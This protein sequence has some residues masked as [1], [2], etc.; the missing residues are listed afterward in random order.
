MK[1]IL[2]LIIISFIFSFTFLETTLAASIERIKGSDRYQTA[3]EISKSGWQSAATV[4]LAKGSDF[5]DA[6]AG[7]P[8]A[9]SLDAPILLTNEMTLTESTKQEILRLKASNIV[10]LGSEGAIS[11]QVETSLRNMG[12]TIDRIGGKHRFETAANI[13]KRISSS[14]AIIANGRNFPDALAVAPYAAKNGIPILLT[15]KEVLPDAT[16]QIAK[17]KSQT[18]IVGKEG[19][20][21]KGVEDRLT[22]TVR[23]GGNDRYHTNQIISEKL[24]MSASKAYVATGENFADAL[25]GSVLAAKNDA[26]ILLVQKSN[27]PTPIKT[28][29]SKYDQ[30]IIYGGIGAISDQVQRT[31]AGYQTEFVLQ[32]IAIG[33]TEQHVL[34]TLGQPAR[35]DLSRHGFNWYI[36]NKDYKKY[37]QVGIKNS[38]VVALYSNS[39]SWESNSGIKLGLKRSLAIAK[40][41]AIGEKPSYFSLDYQTYHVINDEYS[42]NVFYDQHDNESLSAILLVEKSIDPFIGSNYSDILDSTNTSLKDQ[43]RISF[44]KQNLDLTNAYRVRHGLKPLAWDNQ[45]ATAARKHSLD[46]LT[47]NYFDHVNPD[48]KDPFERMEDSGVVFRAAGENIA[49]GYYDAIDVHDGWVNSLGHR[50]NLLGSDYTYLGIGV[51]FGGE[52]G[53]YYTQ[54]FFMK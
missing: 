52:Y 30:F 16:H 32:N 2:V 48:G 53:T 54:N 22:N 19:V 23:Y 44:E 1:K 27:V 31:L 12:L 4:V 42:A 47:R 50:E 8:L 14:K 3:V 6:L 18:I 51:A 9:Y 24:V 7:G 33:D 49:A 20:V 37:I 40:L 36:Y 35:K 29:S 10:I 15:E 13:A 26:T 5:P 21:A 17:S 45:A 38:K 11:K 25:S 39:D 41:D 46:M 43:L 28:I 34:S